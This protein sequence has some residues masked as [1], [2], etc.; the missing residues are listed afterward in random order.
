M[1]TK[2]QPTAEQKAR[3]AERRERFA[4]L[5]KMVSEMS[6]EQRAELVSRVG[7]I[8][9]VEGRPL[10]VHNSCLILTQ[11]PTASVVAGFAQWKNAGRSVKKGEHGLAIWVPTGRGSTAEPTAADVAGAAE[12]EGEQKRPGFVMGTVFDITQ[13]ETEEERAARKEAE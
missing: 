12:G 7:A 2:R 9:T 5:A 10:S 3:A 11:F 13:T 1:K 6:D 4:K 8:V